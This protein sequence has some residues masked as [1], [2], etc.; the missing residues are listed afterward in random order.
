M[1]LHEG[2]DEAAAQQYWRESI[3]LPGAPFTRTFIKPRGTG[4][5]KNHLVHGVCRVR[6][7][8]GADKWNRVMVWIDV[9][10]E[11]LAA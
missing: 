10:R 9:V 5:R 1:H 11:S 2:N 3:G 7:R 6:A 4:H 8:N